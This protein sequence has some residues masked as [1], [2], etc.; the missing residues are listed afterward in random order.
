MKTHRF[1][2]LF[3][4][5]SGGERIVKCVRLAL[6]MKESKEKQRGVVRFLVTEGAAK[7][8]KIKTP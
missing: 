7:R 2:Q 6:E 3:L 1:T 8:H 4:Y 5:Y